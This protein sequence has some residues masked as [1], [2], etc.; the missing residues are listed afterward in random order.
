[1][2][3]YPQN[4]IFP[5]LAKTLFGLEEILAD[6]LKSIGASDIKTSNRSVIFEG[7]M[8]TLYKSNIQ[9]K[10]AGKILVLLDRFAALNKKQLYNNIYKLD[11]NKFLNA[12]S[13]FCIDTILYKSRGFDNS[14]YLAQ[15]AKDA[16]VDKIRNKKGKRPSIN[17][18]DPDLRINLHMNRN[19]VTL[20]FD[21]SG[22]PLHKRG[23]RKEAG[24]APLN[25]LLAAGILKLAE[26]DNNSTLIDGMCGSGTI[27]IEAALS[28]YNIAPGIIKNNYAFLKWNSFDKKLY[29]LI[30]SEAKSNVK[31]KLNIKI[32]AS[33]KDKNMVARAKNNAKNAGVDKY[34]T[35]D[36]LPF[37]DIKPPEQF[38][39]IIINPPYGDRIPIE[40]LHSF[41]KMIGDKFK[42]SFDGYN[43]FVLTGNLE[44]SKYIGLKS[45]KRIKLFNGSL[46]SRLLKFEIYSGSK[47]SFKKNGS[48]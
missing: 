27:P 48:N 33:D 8:N 46:E 47:K 13:T 23:Y 17:T 28:A 16:I 34:I 3:Y 24:E 30:I 26:W 40:K 6:E 41:Y 2:K 14:M 7:D 9:C 19:N 18:S 29:D 10:T 38:G 35:F 11:W 1:M 25:E 12:D 31:T 4:K 44:A 43:A 32:Y 45:S 42:Q 20:S 5:M 15:V 22:S 21:S 39:T 36:C 37:E